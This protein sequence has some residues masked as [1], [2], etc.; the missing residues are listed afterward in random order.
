MCI[1][2]NECF[3]IYLCTHIQFVRMYIHLYLYFSYFLPADAV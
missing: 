2:T 1:Y 3:D